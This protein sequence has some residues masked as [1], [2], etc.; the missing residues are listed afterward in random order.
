MPR[1]DPLV[2]ASY[3]SA[4]TNDNFILEEMGVHSQ[5]ARGIKVQIIG[6][7]MAERLNHVCKKGAAAHLRNK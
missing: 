4:L 1:H 2:P 3:L 7:C 6:E 5:S